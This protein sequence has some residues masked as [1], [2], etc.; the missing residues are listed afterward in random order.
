[1]RVR[2]V[3]TSG[4]DKLIERLNQGL[5]QTGVEIFSGD[6]GSFGYGTTDAP[7]L[8]NKITRALAKRGLGLRRT[9]GADVPAHT[10]EVVNRVRPYTMTSARS[11][12]GLCEAVEYVVR[13]EI[14]GDFVECGVW[15]GGSIMAA[16]LTLL[17]LGIDD[18][19]LY[20][21]DTFAG[22][23]APGE[24]DRSLTAPDQAPADRWRRDLRHDHNEWA[25]AP[26]EAVLANVASTGYPRDRIHPVKG[27]V[28]ETIPGR[29]PHSIAL[30]RLDTDWYSSTRR[31]LEHLYPRL[32]PGGVVIFDDYGAW[33]G[34]RQAVDSYEATGRLLLS[35][36][37][38]TARI[39]VKPGHPG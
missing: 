36:L 31:E 22:M 29:A 30:L 4:R 27:P 25:Y 26:L 20:L 8:R 6:P 37:D 39:A 28:E 19:E 11:I 14:A 10:I 12:I 24:A 7:T 17:R 16:A 33:A 23:P 9:Y 38:D 21:F 15:R 13:N 2:E 5:R 18:R 32:T 1:M 35:R 3:R 34:H